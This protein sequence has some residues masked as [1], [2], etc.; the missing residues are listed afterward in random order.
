MSFGFIDTNVVDWPKDQLLV[1]DSAF[2]R[3]WINDSKEYENGEQ[4]QASFIKMKKEDALDCYF[5]TISATH[6]SILSPLWVAKHTGSEE[7]FIFYD[8][9]T[10]SLRLT[11]TKRMRLSYILKKLVKGFKVHA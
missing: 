9:F 1:Q 6:E 2:I 3:Y 4:I 10:L 7:W 5:H 8:R 11:G